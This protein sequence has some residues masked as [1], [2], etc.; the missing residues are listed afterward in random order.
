V[1]VADARKVVD[2]LGTVAKLPVEVVPFGWETTAAR[3]EGLGATGALRLG[4][5]GQPFRT[6]SGNLIVDC[7][8]GA[9]EEPAALDQAIGQT[10]GVVESGL[11]IGMA[12]TALVA[13]G[14]GVHRL[15]R[16]ATG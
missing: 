3:L 6:D 5:N 2:R 1:I 16:S 8:F 13:Y 12:Q 15:T 10:I 7:A 9:I 14:D 4:A 11:F